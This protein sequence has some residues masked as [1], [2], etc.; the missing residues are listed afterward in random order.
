[1]EVEEF[2]VEESVGSKAAVGTVAR[3]SK[4]AA[5][6]AVVVC[7]GESMESV[8]CSGTRGPEEGTDPLTA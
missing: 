3:E 6:E 1:M 7:F 8:N 4:L 2:Q 5:T